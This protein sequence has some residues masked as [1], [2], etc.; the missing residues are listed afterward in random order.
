[1]QDLVVGAVDVHI[2]VDDDDD[3]GLFVGPYWSGDVG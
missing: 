3:A 2:Y 1:M